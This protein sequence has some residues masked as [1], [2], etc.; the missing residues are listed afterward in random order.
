MTIPAEVLRIGRHDDD[1]RWPVPTG[2][3]FRRDLLRFVSINSDA[4]SNQA[5]EDGVDPIN[6]VRDTHSSQKIATDAWKTI[7]RPPRHPTGPYQLWYQNPD[8]Y[9]LSE[10]CNGFWSETLS[11]TKPITSNQVMEAGRRRDVGYPYVSDR[12]TSMGERSFSDDNT[13]HH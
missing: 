13:R 6:V 11:H 9:N 12:S 10:K 2:S 3:G 7:L 4:Q 5:R 1:R 8:H